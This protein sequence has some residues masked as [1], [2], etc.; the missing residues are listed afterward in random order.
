MSTVFLGL[1]PAL[2]LFVAIDK[3]PDGPVVLSESPPFPVLDPGDLGDFID[4]QAVWPDLD[5][6]VGQTMRKGQKVLVLRHPAREPQADLILYWIPA[7][8]PLRPPPETDDGIHTDHAGLQLPGE[9]LFLGPL[10]AGARSIF[11]LPDATTAQSGR[12]VLYSLPY[13]SVAGVSSPLRLH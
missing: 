4:F 2:T 5:W 9:A 8:R 3:R 10:A 1:I 11:D 13:R 6:Q 12:L 7:N